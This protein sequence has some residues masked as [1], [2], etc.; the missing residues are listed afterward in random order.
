[1]LGKEIDEY[2]VV[3][4]NGFRDLKH[5][6]SSMSALGDIQIG[7]HG[8]IEEG[9]DHSAKIHSVSVPLCVLHAFDDPLIT[10]RTTASNY[11]FMHPENLVKSGS[12]NV[13]LLLT[14]SGGHVGWPTGILPFHDKWKWMSEVAMS[15]GRAVATAKQ[16]SE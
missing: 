2:A 5:Y 3:P 15:F 9:H 10:W 7:K 6:Y 8:Y 4:Y 13:L 14:K 1:L 12:G 11:G 16:I